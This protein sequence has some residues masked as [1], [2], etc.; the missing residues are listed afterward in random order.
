ME[1]PRVLSM[2]EDEIKNRG[3]PLTDTDLSDKQNGRNNILSYCLLSSN[4]FFLNAPHV[5]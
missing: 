2:T 3:Q 4:C 5:Y 1:T